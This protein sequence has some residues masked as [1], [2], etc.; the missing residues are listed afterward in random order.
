[1]FKEKVAQ[2]RDRMGLP[3]KKALR[4][5]KTA[6]ASQEISTGHVSANAPAERVPQADVQIEPPHLENASSKA[7]FGRPG[8]N[9]A[10]DPV[11]LAHGKLPESLHETPESTASNQEMKESPPLERSVI[12]NEIAAESL[13]N[14]VSENKAERLWNTAYIR[15]RAE[16]PMILI[17]FDHFMSTHASTHRWTGISRRRAS[18]IKPNTTTNSIELME[19]FLNGFL[20]NNMVGVSETDETK[21]DE[22]SV[23]SKTQHLN[24]SK[25]EFLRAQ[26]RESVWRSESLIIPWAISCLTFEVCFT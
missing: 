7:A 15:L 24:T 2:L 26:L 22:S 13:T 21:S 20:N 12:R 4:S 25:S 19:K 17:I 5:Q 6:G 16:N 18:Q 23:Q 9:D 3:A 8:P 11:R 1:M 10:Q 14:R